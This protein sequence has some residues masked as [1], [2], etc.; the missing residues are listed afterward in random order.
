MPYVNLKSA[1]SGMTNGADKASGDF[2][3]LPSWIPIQ[4][5]V[6]GGRQDSSSLSK[7][8]IVDHSNVNSKDFSGRLFEYL[9]KLT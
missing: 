9:S 5:Y 2:H 3:K 1:L 7:K 8:I 6:I 4:A